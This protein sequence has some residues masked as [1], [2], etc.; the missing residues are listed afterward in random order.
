MINNIFR[1]INFLNL[2][3]ILTANNLNLNL[4]FEKWIRSHKNYVF[5]TDES[6]Y[7]QSPIEEEYDFIVVS[8]KIFF[9]RNDKKEK[10]MENKNGKIS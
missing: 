6:F 1:Y 2:F 8:K 7:K 4:I 5:G 10:L 3:L 9:Q